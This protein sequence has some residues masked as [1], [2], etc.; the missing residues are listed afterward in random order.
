MFGEDDLVKSHQDRA[1]ILFN[2]IVIA[3]AILIARLWYLQIYKGKQFF[4]YSLE[5]RLRKDVVRAPRGMIFSRNNVLLT[6]N[7]PRFDAIVTPQYLEDEEETI[8][9][10]SKILEMDVE[11]INKI[12]KKYRGQ[13]KYIPVIIK[14]NISRKEV[15]LI[16]T[17]SAK[18]PGI[19]VETFITREYTDKQAGAHLLGY[20]SEISQE[21]LPR[22]RERDK[23]DYKVGDFIGQ[24]GIEQEF[25]LD[26]RGSDGYQFMEVDARGRARRHVNSGDLYTGIENKAPQPGKNIRLTIDRDLQLA[27]F[28]ALEGKDGAAVAIDVRN[29]EVLAM[30]SRPGYDPGQF[31]TGLTSDY[32]SG[33]INDIKRPL[34][35]RAIQEH[36]SPGSTFKTLTHIAALEEGIISHD[37]KVLCTGSYRYGGRNYHCWKKGGHG[38]IDVITALR[39]SCDVFYYQIATKIDIDVIN[40]YATMFGMGQKSGI[41][42]P[43]ETSGLIP[44]KE[45]KKKRFGVEWQRGETLSCVIG[46]SFV[47]VT[48]LQLAMFYS[49]IANGGKLY[50]P[51]VV[52]EV[53]TNTGEVVKRFEPEIINEVKISAPTMKIVRE[54]LYDVVNSPRGTS[55]RN[56]SYGLQM[57]GKTGTAQVVSFSADKIYTKCENHE[58]RFRHHGIFTAYVPSY[59]PR[60]AIAI[61]GEHVCSGSAGAGPIAKQIAEAYMYKYYNKYQEKLMAQ[62]TMTWDEVVK[63]NAV[64][65]VEMKEEENLIQI[66]DETGKQVHDFVRSKVKKKAVVVPPPVA[67]IK[68]TDD[69]GAEE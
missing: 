18:L 61:V 19:S 46:Q 45:W 48:P 39:D 44:T 9:S 31:S 56:K 66:Y 11:S 50:R 15:A 28:H 29:G 16:E 24:A 59:E 6:H 4:N 25:D 32:W 40:K 54:A 47:N 21:K 52:K 34:R 67:V 23:Y 12:M 30:V 65:P 36:Y 35:D 57:S 60:L 58:Y 10:L 13:A 63:D 62:D 8:K 53:F 64:N 1:D 27:A 20:I 17:E 3:F 55:F 26:L 22:F 5:N 33:L 51:H 38:V 49:T 37:S 41:I 42:L 7:I 43:R 68:K 14:K 69:Q 2:L